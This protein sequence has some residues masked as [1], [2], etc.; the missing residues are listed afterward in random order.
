MRTNYD[1][2]RRDGAGQKQ[3]WRRRDPE[4]IF[5]TRVGVLPPIFKYRQ[6]SLKTR[7]SRAFLTS[8]EVF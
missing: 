3:T 2:L 8:F 7:R 1:P 5:Q 6:T 4:V